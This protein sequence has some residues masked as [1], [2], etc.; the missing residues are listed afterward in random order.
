MVVQAHGRSRK[1]LVSQTC[2]IMF[3][4]VALLLLA[5][6]FLDINAAPMNPNC[7]HDRA[8]VQV[9]E[10]SSDVDVRNCKIEFIGDTQ[11]LFQCYPEMTPVEGCLQWS[12]KRLVY[13]CPKTTPSEDCWRD[14]V[15]SHGI[16]VDGT[17]KIRHHI[18]YNEQRAMLEQQVVSLT[19]IIMRKNQKPT[20]PSQ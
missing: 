17:K 8:I 18:G 13:F 16:D 11:K 3:V 6:E 12:K 7:T 19:K 15:C 10:G 14:L 1:E 5:A 4:S 20:R 2:D 9:F